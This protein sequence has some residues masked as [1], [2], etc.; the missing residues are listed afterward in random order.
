MLAYYSRHIIFRGQ[1]IY[2]WHPWA[3]GHASH[4]PPPFYRGYVLPMFKGNLLT[5]T[6]QDLDHLDTA[7]TATDRMITGLVQAV[8]GVQ[9]N[10]KFGYI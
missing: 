9:V 10:I 7:W 3:L 8:Y 2:V 4:Q 6:A 5:T 1:Y